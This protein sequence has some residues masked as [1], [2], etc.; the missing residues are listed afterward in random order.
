ML[1]YCS[2]EI[3]TSRVGEVDVESKSTMSCQ[4]HQHPE[5]CQRSESCE[6]CPQSQ[7]VLVAPLGTER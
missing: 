7:K 2:I 3:E 5:S 1:I 4:C 6:K